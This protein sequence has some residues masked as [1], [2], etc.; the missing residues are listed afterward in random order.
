MLLCPPG[1]IFKG[2]ECVP[3]LRNFTRMPLKLFL[4]VTPDIHELV[5]SDELDFS[6]Q[7]LTQ[8]AKSIVTKLKRI[9]DSRFGPVNI[10]WCLLFRETS[11][12][13]KDYM[14][15]FFAIIFTF[16][17]A[18][19]NRITRVFESFQLGIATKISS[20]PVKL[21]IG[22]IIG[23]DQKS[24]V[25]FVKKGGL[26]HSDNFEI[27]RLFPPVI[28]KL[29]G[30]KIALRF[31]QTL[32][33]LVYCKRI[34]LERGELELLRNDSRAVG[35]SQPYLSYVLWEEDGSICLEDFEAAFAPSVADTTTDTH[36]DTAHFWLTYWILWKLL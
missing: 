3:F 14:K 12:L 26:L 24:Q 32:S 23:I 1:N 36:W 20:V 34:K 4:E 27:E 5:N 9:I 18:N 15:T 17:D 7:P 31:S 35:L 8:V 30:L 6:V 22:N 10:K 21:S 2:C 16:K 19:E 33:K 13:D 29:S 25:F 28:H 11:K